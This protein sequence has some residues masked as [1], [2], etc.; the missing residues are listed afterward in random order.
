VIYSPVF[1]PPTTQT[2]TT[3]GTFTTGGM[4]TT[5]G[6]FTTGGMTTTG[7]TFTTGGMTTTGGSTAVTTVFPGGPGNCLASPS[8]NVVSDSL[9]ACLPLN[10]M[11]PACSS[12]NPFGRRRLL[13]STTPQVRVA[14]F[15]Q[16]VLPHPKRPSVRA[17]SSACVLQEADSSGLMLAL[18]AC[19]GLTI[20]AA[21]V[22]SG[23]VLVR[24]L[25]DKRVEEYIESRA[26]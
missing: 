3:G 26:A 11:G 21:M 13:S 16:L 17:H 12:S 6:T 25:I 15:A 9:C 10:Q 7:G 24:H 4:T 2:V 19:G 20:I 22:A 18:S 1:V 23:R 8:W 5:G 14:A